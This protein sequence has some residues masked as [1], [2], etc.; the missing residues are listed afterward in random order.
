MTTGAMLAAGSSAPGE[1]PRFALGR[2]LVGSSGSPAALAF[3]VA[4]SERVLVIDVSVPLRSL[5]AVTVA[6]PPPAEARIEPLLLMLVSE[7]PAS[8]WIAVALAA[9][10]LA[11]PP[12]MLPEL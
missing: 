5:M 1:P 2:Q 6:A 11:T 10:S 12:V 4:W 7:A 3:R 9:T 8:I